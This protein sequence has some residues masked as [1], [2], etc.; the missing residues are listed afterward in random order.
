MARPTVKPCFKK[1]VEKG[2]RSAIT[3]EG[4]DEAQ[5]PPL[6]ASWTAT[7][8]RV[9]RRPSVGGGRHALELVESRVFRYTYSLT[10]YSE[11]EVDGDENDVS[12]AGD[13]RAVVHVARVPFERLAVH[14]Q[15]DRIL[16][17]VSACQH[18]NREY[19]R[20]ATRVSRRRLT[21]RICCPS[22]FRLFC[23]SVRTRLVKNSKNSGA[24]SVR[25][26][27]ANATMRCDR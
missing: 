24:I 11:P 20:Y 4:G 18:Q 26:W 23:R 6:L 3:S 16:C 2:K 12:E 25:N 17:S 21:G 27:S 9:G 13:D 14:E 22:F 7:C 8:R 19:S 5:A 1:P 10:E 15:Y